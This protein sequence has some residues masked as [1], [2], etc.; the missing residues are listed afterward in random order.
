MSGYIRPD[1]H[2]QW[3]RFGQRSRIV[4]GENRRQISYVNGMMGGQIGGLRTGSSRV[5]VLT[6]S[7]PILADAGAYICRVTSEIPQIVTIRLQV[8]QSCECM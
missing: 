8:L 4:S 3:F 7:N 6:I 5:S 2:L 1:D